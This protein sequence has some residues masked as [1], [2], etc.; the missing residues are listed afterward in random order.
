[1]RLLLTATALSALVLG[2]LNPVEAAKEHHTKQA[3]HAKK[4][5][6]RDQQ[7]TVNERLDELT[8]KVEELR[9]TRLT[10]DTGVTDGN[11]LELKITGQVNKAALYVDN[12]KN[13][14]TQYVD[15][16]NEFTVVD[17]NATG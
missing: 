11:L 1:M 9:D 5:H 17:L 15:N 7:L 4:H 13:T 16:N 14:N 2:G 10:D 6:H 3:R 8:R 12:G